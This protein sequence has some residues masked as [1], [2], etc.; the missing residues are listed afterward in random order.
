MSMFPDDE[1]LVIASTVGYCTTSV[2]TM[3]SEGLLG[4][5]QLLTIFRC[6]LGP[7]TD[8]W[9]SR[10][11]VSSTT[12]SAREVSDG[13]GRQL[14]GLVGDSCDWEVKLRKHEWCLLLS[15]RL[16][17][18]ASSGRYERGIDDS[19]GHPSKNGIMGM[20]TYWW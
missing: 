5:K 15:R 7:V 17:I 9:G 19:G 6:S 18:Q 12:F 4:Q 3:K 8:C 10:C 20:V 11:L 13:I 2:R 14:L 16:L 1:S